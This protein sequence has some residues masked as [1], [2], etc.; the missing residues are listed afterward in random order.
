MRSTIYVGLALLVA[1]G[2]ATLPTAPRARATKAARAKKPSPRRD[3][4]GARVAVGR[5]A[6]VASGG[7]VARPSYLWALL[8]NWMYFLS[9]GLTVPNLPRIIASVVNEDGTLTGWLLAYGDG[10]HFI[11]P[12]SYFHVEALRYYNDGTLVSTYAR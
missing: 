7:A 1:T 4:V 12:L 3:D 11:N 2:A 9:L 5:R 10:A 8:H 6:A